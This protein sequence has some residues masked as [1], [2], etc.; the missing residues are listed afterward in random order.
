VP[1]YVAKVDATNEEKQEYLA[2]F[3]ESVAKGLTGK[4]SVF[5]LEHK[6]LVSAIDLYKCDLAR[7]SFSS[8]RSGNI[9]FKSAGDSGAF[10]DKVNNSRELYSQFL[11][12]YWASSRGDGTL[13]A[14]M[15][16]QRSDVGEFKIV[17]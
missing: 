14:Q 6:W 12:A 1:G 10:N 5:A 4:N 13:F 16:L 15:G 11:R 8:S 9:Q 2:G 7:Q 17:L 3:N